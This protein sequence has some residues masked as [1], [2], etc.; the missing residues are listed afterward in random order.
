M[1]NGAWSLSD[2]ERTWNQVVEETL[3]VPIPH[4]TVNGQEFE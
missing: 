1:L 3:D 4:L 2:D